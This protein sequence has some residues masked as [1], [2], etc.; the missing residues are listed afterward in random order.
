MN[1]DAAPDSPTGRLLRRIICVDCDPDSRAAIRRACLDI[2]DWDAVVHQAELHGL[3]PYLHRQITGSGAE[4]PTQYLRKLKY[5]T[6]RHRD[7]NRI[8][9]RA[10]TEMIEIL[11]AR[12][13]D[14]L[15]L[16]GAALAHLV[17]ESP[18]LRPMSDMDL[19]VAPDRLE[20]AS[21]AVR[22]LGYTEPGRGRPPADH[23]HLPAMSR[24]ISGL[25]ISVEIHHDAIAPDN[26]GSIRLDSL[27]EPAREFRIDDT[28]ARALGHIDM[29]RHLWRHALQPRETMK[30]GSAL[31]IVLY[32]S[33]F[34]EDIDW[35]RI[36]RD[37]PEIVTGLSLLGYLVRL[38]PAL[39]GHVPAPASPPP[40]GVG[41]GMAP[42]SKLRHQRHLVARLLDPSDWWLRGF[43]NVPPGRPLVVTKTI[44]HPARILF[45]LWRRIGR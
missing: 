23:H 8:R 5:L 22:R 12:G 1:Q 37:F 32:A 15:L 11:G 18:G 16:K 35:P 27:T 26:I 31:D 36:E 21:D 39:A 43:Y 42:L 44:R 41:I 38:P 17:Y 19:L 7:A 34:A 28:A 45:W 20:D 2:A 4:I 14:V 29:L 3:A 9:D 10:L 24:T 13:I 25:G 40:G 30:L 33:C 6:L